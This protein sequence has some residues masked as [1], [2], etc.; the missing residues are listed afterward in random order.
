[1]ALGKVQL[2]LWEKTSSPM[3]ELVVTS[4]SARETWSL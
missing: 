1:M 4:M 2:P 3:L